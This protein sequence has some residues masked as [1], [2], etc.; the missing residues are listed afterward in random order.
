MGRR[1]WDDGRRKTDDGQQATDNR[2]L[3]NDILLVIILNT[4]Y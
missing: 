1:I 3:P 4:K 2:P